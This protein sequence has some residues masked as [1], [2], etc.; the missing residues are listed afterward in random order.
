M[1]NEKYA[2]EIKGFHSINVPS[3]WELNNIGNLILLGGHKGS[4][5]IQLM[6]PASGNNT[7]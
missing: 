5:S 4:V 1:L 3:E 2:Q 6:S 7:I